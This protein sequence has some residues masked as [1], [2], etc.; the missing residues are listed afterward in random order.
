[1]EH[2]VMTLLVRRRPG[3]NTECP[4]AV[5]ITFPKELSP[6]EMTSLTSARLIHKRGN[7]ST[8]SETIDSYRPQEWRAADLS[9]QAHYA[10]Q[11][12]GNPRPWYCVMRSL[13]KSV[14]DYPGSG[15]KYTNNGQVWAGM[16]KLEKELK[17]ERKMHQRCEEELEAEWKMRV[18]GETGTALASRDDEGP[19]VQWAWRQIGPR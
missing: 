7:R 11:F 1:M 19:S 6:G 18:T 8:V 13:C 3:E 17:T 4:Y 10:A 12:N 15:D 5:Q 2:I 16:D 14:Y 9:E